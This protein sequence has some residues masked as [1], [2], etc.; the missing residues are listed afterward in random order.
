M[1]LISRVYPRTVGRSRRPTGPATAPF[2]GPV[3]PGARAAAPGS[4]GVRAD[5]GRAQALTGRRERP[6]SSPKPRSR[7]LH[8]WGPLPTAGRDA[9]PTPACPCPLTT[10]AARA[11]RVVPTGSPPVGAATRPCP[12][13]PVGGTAAP[14]PAHRPGPPP[15]PADA[16]APRPAPAAPPLSRP[17]REATRNWTAPTTRRTGRAAAGSCSPRSRAPP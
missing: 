4:T 15:W 8:S 17:G 13:S 12:V 1:W 16:A 7:V 2:R 3:A 10:P 11:A 5:G 14:A 9:S 6:C